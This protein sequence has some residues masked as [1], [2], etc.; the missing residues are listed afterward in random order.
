MSL[1][2]ATHSPHEQSAGIRSLSPIN[3]WPKHL[4]LGEV[5][6]T[7]YL[8]GPKLRRGWARDLAEIKSTARQD[9]SKLDRYPTMVVP[10]A[11]ALFSYGATVPTPREWRIWNEKGVGFGRVNHEC[12]IRLGHIY[13]ILSVHIDMMD[14][15]TLVHNCIVSGSL[16][17]LFLGLG[18]SHTCVI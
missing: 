9:S 2:Q 17:Q 10:N 12:L 8:M 18:L 16:T 15:V 13:L 7:S 5:Q 14:N 6:Q 1:A 4:S 3:S 11:R